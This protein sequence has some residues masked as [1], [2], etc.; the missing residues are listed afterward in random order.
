MDSVVKAPT[1]LLRCNDDHA[2]HLVDCTASVSVFPLSDALLIPHEVF[3]QFDLRH[4]LRGRGLDGG[5]DGGLQSWGGV[6]TEL[7]I[8]VIDNWQLAHMGCTSSKRLH[9]W[10]LWIPDSE[11]NSESN[12]NHVGFLLYFVDPDSSGPICLMPRHHLSLHQEPPPRHQGSSHQARHWNAGLWPIQAAWRGALL[13]TAEGEVL[14][15]FGLLRRSWY[16]QGKNLPHWLRI[17]L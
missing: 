16:P 5:Q 1:H 10:V 7:T 15:V 11:N 13:A 12:V 8:K 17:I 9:F 6:S 4:R 14:V 3:H 2:L